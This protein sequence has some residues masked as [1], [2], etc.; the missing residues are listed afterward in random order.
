M[1][2]KTWFLHIT[3]LGVIYRKWLALELSCFAWNT[4]LLYT[5]C[6]CTLTAEELY[7]VDKTAMADVLSEEQPREEKEGAESPTGV[8]GEGEGGGGGGGEEEGEREEVVLLELEEIL[9][10]CDQIQQKVGKEGVGEGVE[11]GE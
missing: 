8:E 1:C 9:K 11:P 6:G 2:R 4:L 7:K 10:T 3:C 5:S